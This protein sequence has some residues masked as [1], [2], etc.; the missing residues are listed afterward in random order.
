ML[1]DVVVVVIV[2]IIWDPREFFRT[3]ESSGRFRRIT[4]R[5]GPKD[6]PGLL[7]NIWTDYHSDN[8]N[9]SEPINR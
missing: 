7:R 6:S 5:S 9:N 8:Y 2:R 3:N 1:V 4:T